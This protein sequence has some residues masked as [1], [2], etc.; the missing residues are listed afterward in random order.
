MC[1]T[2]VCNTRVS[3]CTTVG[4]AATRSSIHSPCVLASAYLLNHDFCNSAIVAEELISIEYERRR[5]GSVGKAESDALGRGRLD[6]MWVDADLPYMM[7][8]GARALARA[9]GT[10]AMRG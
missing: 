4:L 9:P 2:E 10:L 6:L 3:T 1:F 8:R 7:V 5:H